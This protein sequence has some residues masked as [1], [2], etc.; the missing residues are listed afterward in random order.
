[1]PLAMIRTIIRTLSLVNQVIMPYYMGHPHQQYCFTTMKPYMY[2]LC[3]KHL[4]LTQQASCVSK[5]ICT[6][7]IFRKIASFYKLV[8]LPRP[9]GRPSFL[10]LWG[11][12][13]WSPTVAT[14]SCMFP[15]TKYIAK[16]H[17]TMACLKIANGL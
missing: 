15:S 8:Y 14:M 3:S 12:D 16:C 4:K 2:I 6:K 13:K 11:P 1:M 10:G 17:D 9:F 7:V 5:N